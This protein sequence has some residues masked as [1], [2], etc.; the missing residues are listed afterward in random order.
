MNSATHGT[1]DHYVFIL[2]SA[3]TKNPADISMKSSRLPLYTLN[4]LLKTK[5]L[6]LSLRLRKPSNEWVILRIDAGTVYCSLLQS[7][8]K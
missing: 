1:N 3:Y 7:F 5:D 2:D 6:E 8:V 4:L